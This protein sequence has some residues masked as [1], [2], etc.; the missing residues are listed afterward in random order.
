MTRARLRGRF[1]TGAAPDPR[2]DRHRPGGRAATSVTTRRPDASRVRRTSSSLTR[3]RCS[4]T[5]SRRGPP[6]RRPPPP[7]LRPPPDG[8]RRGLR[9]GR[10][11]DRRRRGSSAGP[12]SPNC[13]LRLALPERLERRGLATAELPLAPRGARGRGTLLAAALRTLGPFRTLGARA[14]RRRNRCRRPPPPPPS[15][16][17]SPTSESE[18]LPFWSMSSTFTLSSSPS[19]STSSTRSMRLP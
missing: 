17:S 14:V 6:P 8:R 15:P 5:R 4:A 10:R 18:S 19:E 3:V 9:R 7:P 12:R 16:L 2:A 1:V 11:R 13:S